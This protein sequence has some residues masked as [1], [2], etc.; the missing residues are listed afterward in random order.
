MG[1]EAKK[2]LA[3]NNRMFEELKFHHNEAAD[4]QTEKNQLVASLTTAKR[5]INIFADKE[6]EYAKQG[7]V[8]TKEIRALRE[9][10]VCATLTNTACTIVGFDL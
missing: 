4:L 9:R 2:I 8:R 6:V 7:H 1:E 5:D 10:Y 3:D